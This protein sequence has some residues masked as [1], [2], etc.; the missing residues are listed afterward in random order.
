ML[1]KFVW[2]RKSGYYLEPAIKAQSDAERRTSCLKA[3]NLSPGLVHDIFWECCRVRWGK[4]PTKEEANH[5]DERVSTVSICLFFGRGGTRDNNYWPP[6]DDLD[7]DES[8]THKTEQNKQK[9]KTLHLLAVPD[10]SVWTGNTDLFSI[11][12]P[13]KYRFWKRSTFQSAC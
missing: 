2:N 11:F 12:F 5:P 1:Q 9:N 10:I 4:M 6:S 7:T 3:T 8:V 13:Q